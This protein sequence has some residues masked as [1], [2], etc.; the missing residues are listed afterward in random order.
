MN[1]KRY[2]HDQPLSDD[3]TFF[4]EQLVHT[5]IPK[6]YVHGLFIRQLSGGSGVSRRI[7]STIIVNTSDH[8]VTELF[9]GLRYESQSSEEGQGIS[10][11]I[12]LFSEGVT[13]WTGEVQA[14]VGNSGDDSNNG[15]QR[16]QIVVRVYQASHDECRGF[17]VPCVVDYGFRSSV[18]NWNWRWIGKLNDV[19][20]V[21][22]VGYTFRGCPPLFDISSRSLPSMVSPDFVGEPFLS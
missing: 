19:F 7:Y 1:R 6:E 4:N 11:I 9:T 13:T 22:T 8:Q 2:G 3:F 20:E 12:A 14:L 5:Q 18:F 21:G 16:Q 15:R 17:V 10:D